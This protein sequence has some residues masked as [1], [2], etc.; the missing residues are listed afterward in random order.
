MTSTNTTD[1]EHGGPTPLDYALAEEGLYPAGVL[2]AYGRQADELVR[3]VAQ[4]L[5]G[6][7]TQHRERLAHHSEQIAL[8]RE[9]MARHR[10]EMGQLTEQHRRRIALLT[11][12]AER[13]GIAG[14]GDRPDQ[15]GVRVNTYVDGEAASGRADGR[16]GS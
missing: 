15:G 6:E 4:A 8:H 2:A 10:D 1:V 7:R 16:C 5:A 9:Q 13:L 11:L 12:L 14:T 3:M